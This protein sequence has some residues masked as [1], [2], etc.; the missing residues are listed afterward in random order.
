M[1]TEDNCQ[2]KFRIR[3]RFMIDLCPLILTFH[4]ALF[5]LRTH[6]SW[7][8][9]GPCYICWGW[10]LLWQCSEAKGLPAIQWWV[11][12]PRNKTLKTFWRFCSHLFVNN[13]LEIIQ[14]KRKAAGF[15]NMFF[16][17]KVQQVT[18]DLSVGVYRKGPLS[19]LKL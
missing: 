3:S 5:L 7:W 4:V 10:V 16:F 8:C 2:N 17:F 13:S 19:T 9:L 11:Y 1:K 18:P 14:Q 12:Q 6:D 15:Q